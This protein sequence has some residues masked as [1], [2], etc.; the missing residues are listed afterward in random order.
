MWSFNVNYVTMLF[1]I[2]SNVMCEDVIVTGTKVHELS[3]HSI[4]GRSTHV[5]RVVI[6]Q[7]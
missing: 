2:V 5:I 3:I 7:L 1:T 6:N 4:K